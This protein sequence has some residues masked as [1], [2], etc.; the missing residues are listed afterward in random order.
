MV[1][2][3][4]TPFPIK[5]RNRQLENTF[6]FLSHRVSLKEEWNLHSTLFIKV[7]NCHPFN[8]QPE[9]GETVLNSYVPGSTWH[10]CR[11]IMWDC[12]CVGFFPSE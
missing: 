9:G 12:N 4:C 11:D 2:E 10:H 6:F 7:R 1:M 3:E 8:E 5:Q